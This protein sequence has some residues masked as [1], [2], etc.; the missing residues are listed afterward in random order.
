MVATGNR[1]AVL[2]LRISPGGLSYHTITD[3][4]IADSRSVVFD[5]G[6][7]FSL[8]E[9]RNTLNDISDF[10]RV[11]DK[12]Q[13]VL[14]SSNV[15]YAPKDVADKVGA[16]EILISADMQPRDGERALVSGESDGVVAVW[17]VGEAFVNAITWRFAHCP[18][19]EFFSPLHENIAYANGMGRVKH[20]LVV[21]NILKDNL[22]YLQ[23][24]RNGVLQ[25]AA[26]YPCEGMA[27][28][29]YMVALIAKDDGLHKPRYVFMGSLSEEDKNF[30]KRNFK[31]CVCE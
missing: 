26:A 3:S 22:Y 11:Y 14:D 29:A 17:P 31:R 13:V 23:L 16:G 28:A 8:M 20:T 27:D 19:I 7:D 4:G 2:T 10:D 25:R 9:L 15:V 21:A 1:N 6:A 24:D 30:L 18:A 12:V 5:L